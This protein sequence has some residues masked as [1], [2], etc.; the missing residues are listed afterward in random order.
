[1]AAA[2]PVSAADVRT[3][4]NLPI[5]GNIES[6]LS[7]HSAAAISYL[8]NHV[9][10]THYDEATSETPGSAL[11]SAFRYAY[12]FILF[13]SVLEFINIKTIGTGIIKSTG[14]DDQAAELLTVKD[15]ASFKKSLELR[16]L[17][18]I[19]DYFNLT[20]KNRYRE[21]LT[22]S[23]SIRGTRAS[24]ISGDDDDE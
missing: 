12:S 6:T 9:E 23:Q 8:R 24:V 1:M 11:A 7:A 10:K 13:E 3:I 22:G 15:I 2:I 20:G 5:D 21:L 18:Q 19:I 17:T 14:I 4:V 16:A